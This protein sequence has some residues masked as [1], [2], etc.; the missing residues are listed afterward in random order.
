[1]KLRAS[2]GMAAACALM[3][4][5]ANALAQDDS[6]EKKG[7]KGHADEMGKMAQ[8][9]DPEMKAWMEA[10]TPGPNHKLLDYSVGTW[11]TLVRTWDQKTG[12]TQESTGKS[13]SKWVL[14]GHYVKTKYTGEFMGMPFEGIGICG[15]DNIKKTFV[16][17]WMDSM[18]TGIVTEQGSYDPASKT[19]TFKSE[20]PDPSGKTIKSK[21]TIKIIDN[22]KHV[23]TMYHS[24][25]GKDE[26]VKGLEITYT[27]ADKSTQPE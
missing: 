11:D 4:L 20:F 12:E 3:L 23:L 2:M 7:M 27:R 5:T 15:Y 17:T 13:T 22:N 1:M 16:S 9:M 19:F 26:L 25:P 21:S 10:A 18:S 6:A 14:D 8:E 24:E